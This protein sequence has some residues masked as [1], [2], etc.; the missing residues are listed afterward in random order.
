MA[1]KEFIISP[2]NYFEDGFFDGDYTER[3][4]QSFATLTCEVDKTVGF[5]FQ[6]G[7]YFEEGFIEESF[8][9]I[10][11]IVA[12]L[13]VEA[14]IVQEAT[15]NAT[16]YYQDNYFEQ[17]Y[18]TD[19][20]S[21][22]T[23]SI[24]LGQTVEAAGSI[25]ATATVDAV[26]GVVKET[27]ANVNAEFS[28]TGTISHI[29]GA[30]LFAFAEAAL[31]AAVQASREYSA[32]VD[33]I[34]DIATDYVRFRT[35]SAE[36]D[37][38]FT[39]ATEGVRSRDFDTVIEAAVSLD[40]SVTKTVQAVVDISSNF[41]ITVN[42][43]NLQEAEASLISEFNCSANAI[44]YI[45]KPPYSTKVIYGAPKYE[46]VN[47]DTSLS[48]FGQA[49]ASRI[50]DTNQ[51]TSISPIAWDG[52]K[53]CYLGLKNG[54]RAFF[55]STDLENWTHNLITGGADSYSDLIYTGT[56]YVGL[57]SGNSSFEVSSDG[58]S[59][60]TISPTITISSRTLTPVGSRI[61]YL[62]GFFYVLFRWT[63]GGSIVWQLARNSSMSATGWTNVTNQGS[64][65]QQFNRQIGIMG[66]AVNGSSAVFYFFTRVVSTS[67][68]LVF[69]LKT[70]NNGSTWGSATTYSPGT[71]LGIYSTI[72]NSNSLAI[73]GSTVY[74][75]STNDV[76]YSGANAV[77]SPTEK[78][79][80]IAIL[81]NIFF[82]N[83]LSGN[84]TKANTGNW[85]SSNTAISLD[86]NSNFEI[87]TIDKLRFLN[88]KYVF[89]SNQSTF[90]DFI[91]TVNHSTD[92]FNFTFNE[93]PSES[94]KSKAGLSY[95]NNEINQWNTIDF[96]T[97][98]QPMD[99]NKVFAAGLINVGL[100]NF[101]IQNNTLNSNS[102][103][104]RL[105]KGNEQ[106]AATV[107]QNA[108]DQWLHCRILKSNTNLK[109]YLNGNQLFEITNYD[110]ITIDDILV[111]G[112][113]TSFSNNNNSKV[114]VDDVYVSSSLLNTYSA[115]SI[116][117]PTSPYSFNTDTVLYLP[118][119]AS[120]DEIGRPQLLSASAALFST[121]NLTANLSYQ[122]IGAS[123]QVSEATLTVSADVIS[124]S[125]I[126]AACAAE[127]ITDITRI[128][129]IESNLNSSATQIA[130]AVKLVNVNANLNSEFSAN[131]IISKTL[132]GIIETDSIAIL[133]TAVA[134][135]GDFLVTLENSA[136]LSADVVKTT[137]VNST[138]QAVTAVVAEGDK[139]VDFEVTLDTAVN[140]SIIGDRIRSADSSQTASFVHSITAI[141]NTQG[142]IELNSAF[143]IE[144]DSAGLIG[145]DAELIS[146]FELDTDFD[147]TRAFDSALASEITVDASAIKAVE[148]DLAL[149]S[150][151][152]HTIEYDRIRN[153]DT[154]FDS[155]AITVS[156][157]S[158][159]GDFFINA[160][161]SFELDINVIISAGAL[162]E[163]NSLSELT[164]ANSRSRDTS[165]VLESEV[166]I[167][168]NARTA[169]DATL[170]AQIISN[171]SVNTN[172][173]TSAQI[174]V[175]SALTFNT[176]V[177]ATRNNEIQTFT[178]SSLTADVRV[179]RSAV[180]NS[181]STT[182]TTINIVRSRAATANISSNTNVV[183]SGRIIVIDQYEY[184]IP[185]EFREFAIHA[186]NRQYRIVRETREHIVRG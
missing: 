109:F 164:V 41:A 134:K 131:A 36:A 140:I 184:I 58:V 48:K 75:V 45:R 71:S 133:L 177:V 56:Q 62:G 159:I 147:R 28:C 67:Q 24:Y 138:I 101:E 1:V 182:S 105:M 84:V 44:E 176:S 27:S 86:V 126:D 152:A 160:D 115:T 108:Q 92:G 87:D 129:N 39:Q 169:T 146:N 185:R 111:L 151:F 10:N 166:T 141:K 32:S 150:N 3:Q 178:Q 11:S 17:G 149:E 89:L 100:Y 40:A 6:A 114:Y 29:E 163:L 93:I 23:F 30:D 119:D 170:D 107:V 171:L 57:T 90:K 43:L 110:N 127:Q 81:N 55:K 148:A 38:E 53:W 161:S 167:V 124:D 157:V 162:V 155:I 59:W 113:R 88:S 2:G 144:I 154:N 76:I 95:S 99:A 51:T 137:D 15:V 26:V 42:A 83:S 168:A 153:V 106:I 132:D 20:G 103:R 173:I 125:I 5:V 97:Y 121:V 35:A 85:A 180:V 82:Y 104:I 145:G 12:T 54:A 77:F 64:G 69:E 18:Y 156:A 98:A 7:F 65:G 118:Y 31:A 80:S 73:S 8:T 46:Q 70:S 116:S 128:R 143:D 52:T 63:D 13:E 96:W 25:S 72:R 181:V 175:D 61:V 94:I 122:S 49:S 179:I 37:S 74:R 130:D 112:N 172:V 135:V 33:S 66:V 91:G 68:Y 123:L 79:S 22:F 117:V 19:S 136:Q 186:E 139:T 60:N 174:S 142:I 4:N 120:L 158:K 14:M 21:R 183:V 102:I 50:Y 165:A 9:F 16:N 47:L 34:F 78:V